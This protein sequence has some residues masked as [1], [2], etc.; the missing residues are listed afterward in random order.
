MPEENEVCPLGDEQ[1]APSILDSA[2]PLA[3]L[4]PKKEIGVDRFL[5]AHPHYDGRGIIVAIF[6]NSCLT[7]AVIYNLEVLQIIILCSTISYC[8]QI[9]CS[10]QPLICTFRPLDSGVD[11]AAAGLQTTADGKP[12]LIDIVDW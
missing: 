3:G 6:G 12:K 5:G 9:L 1:V 10:Q 11:P 2:S 8:H 7:C 4:M